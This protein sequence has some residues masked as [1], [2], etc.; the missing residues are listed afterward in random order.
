MLKHQLHRLFVIQAQDRRG[1]DRE[2]ADGEGFAQTPQHD[3]VL[4]AALDGPIELLVAASVH[5]HRL[6][7]P[8][9]HEADRCEGFVELVDDGAGGVVRE[10]REVGDFPQRVVAE[11]AKII[12]CLQELKQFIAHDDSF[13]FQHVDWIASVS[14]VTFCCQKRWQADSSPVCGSEPGGGDAARP[15][16]LWETRSWRTASWPLRHSTVRITLASRASELADGYV[17]LRG[18]PVGLRR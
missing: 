12:V 2:H 16:I 9:E 11:A 15:T 18:N 14:G 8:P 3:A 10:L 13:R 4:L 1:L 6:E 5:A 17:R 7:P